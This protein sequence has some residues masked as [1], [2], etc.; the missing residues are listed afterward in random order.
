ME[1]LIDTV[2]VDDDPYARE[3]LR[4]Q[5]SQHHPQINVVAEASNGKEGYDV[6]R[7]TDPDLVFLDIRMPYQSGIELIDRFVDRSFYT[8]FHSNVTDYAIEAIKRQ[9]SGYLL[10]PLDP[11]ELNTCLGKL[12]HR[13]QSQHE[14]LPKQHFQKLEVFAKGKVRYVKHSDIMTIEACGSYSNIRLKTGERLMVSKNLKQ[15]QALLGSEGFFRA[16]NSFIINLR[17]VKSCNYSLKLCT[18]QNGENIKLAVRRSE[19]LRRKLELLWS[20]HR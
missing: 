2:I 4:R 5:L 13:I 11:D 20:V 3:L 17:G 6:I 15:L 1:R 10:K 18:M 16:H 19:E 9:A 14:I 8:I 7:K 12:T